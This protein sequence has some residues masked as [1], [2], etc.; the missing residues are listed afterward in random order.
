M[1]VAVTTYV[2]MGFLIIRKEHQLTHFSSIS[3]DVTSP[4]SPC[5]MC[6]QVLREFC[7]LKAPIVMASSDYIAKEENGSWVKTGKGSVKEL[8]LEEL[9]P[10]SFGPEDLD[11][12]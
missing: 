9:L 5:G 8:T 2:P 10:L 7:G 11:R 3:S 12:V 1:A 6:R 4:V